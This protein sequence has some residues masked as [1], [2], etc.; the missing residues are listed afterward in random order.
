MTCRIKFKTNKPLK[1]NRNHIWVIVLLISNWSYGQ[2]YIKTNPISPLFSIVHVGVETQLHSKFSIEVDAT[3]SLARSHNGK[4]LELTLITTELRYYPKGIQKG[5]F[6]GTHVAGSYFFLQKYN[7]QN[8]N[9]VQKGYNYMLGGSIGYTFPLTK[10]WNL[11]TYL[12][13]GN[14]HSFYKGYD[15]E[16]SNRYDLAKKWN[17]SGEWLPYR[18]GLNLVYRIR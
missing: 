8:T 12:G 1:Q 2:T 17:K 13:G 18:I 4:P 10:Q 7:Y 14:I 11:E 15:Y 16:T 3:Q 6:F 9:S 5:W